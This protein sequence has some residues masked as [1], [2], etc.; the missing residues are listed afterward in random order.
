MTGAELIVKERQRQIEEEGWTA[1][2]DDD[3]VASELLRASVCYCLDVLVKIGAQDSIHAEIAELVD[4]FWPW[5]DEWWKPTFD[6]SIR[7]LTK[8][9]ALIAAEIDRIQ[10]QEVKR[11]TNQNG[12]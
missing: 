12:T 4:R 2:H 7:Q 11:V 3:F 8:A 1:E 10:R 9:G 6:N 5:S